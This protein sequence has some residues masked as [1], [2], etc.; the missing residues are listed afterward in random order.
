MASATGTGTPT[1]RRRVAG[2]T[3]SV[4]MMN[5]DGSPGVTVDANVGAKIKYLMAIAIALLAGGLVLLAGAGR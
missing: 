1:L 2:G 4:V 5:A 3:W